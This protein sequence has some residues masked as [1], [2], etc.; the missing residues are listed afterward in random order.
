MKCQFCK[1]FI[2]G[3]SNYSLHHAIPPN[4]RVSYTISGAVH[5]QY[6]R[7]SRY[8]SAHF[9]SRLCWSWCRVAFVELDTELTLWYKGTTRKVHK[10]EP[11]Q[12][13]TPTSSSY[14]SK[15]SMEHAV[16]RN[17]YGSNR[18]LQSYVSLFNSIQTSSRYGHNVYEPFAADEVHQNHVW[19]CTDPPVDIYFLY[20][21]YASLRAH[22][23]PRKGSVP[24][25]T[26]DGP[27]LQA[28]TR[29]A[30]VI[31]ITRT[32]FELPTRAKRESNAMSEWER[33]RGN[34]A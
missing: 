22:R 19:R 1:S 10:D 29:K 21:S 34:E 20:T 13:R 4:A 18:A 28:L 32:E 11:P 30:R 14:P 24:T 9:P 26:V 12:Y 3:S 17:K 25:T 15:N 27:P 8:R 31:H 2:R 5:P 16:I 33:G 23:R 7:L 6:D